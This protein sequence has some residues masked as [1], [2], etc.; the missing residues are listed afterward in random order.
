VILEEEW[1]IFTSAHPVTDYAPTVFSKSVK[2]ILVMLLFLY[3]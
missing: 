2:C 3:L 1:E